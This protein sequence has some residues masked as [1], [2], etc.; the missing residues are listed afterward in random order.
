MAMD[1]VAISFLRPWGKGSDLPAVIGPVQ[2]GLPLAGP[3]GK[4]ALDAVLPDLG[5]VP[6]HGLP[7]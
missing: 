6:L 4:V 3:A 1:P 2:Q 7:S 5:D